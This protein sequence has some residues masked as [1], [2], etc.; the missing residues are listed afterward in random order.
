MMENFLSV[1]KETAIFMLAAQMILHFLPGDKYTKYGKMIAA[2]VIFSRLVLPVLSFGDLDFVTEFSEKVQFYEAENTLFTHELENLAQQQESLWL[3]DLMGSVE[4]QL[5]AVASQNGVQISSVDM[6][7][8]VMVI[9]VHGDS[10]AGDA[11]NENVF[12]SEESS[13]KAQ[14]NAAS[15]LVEPVTV[16]PVKIGRERVKTGGESGGFGQE[17]G[18]V[19]GEK[20]ST[21][22]GNAVRGRRRSDLEERFAKKLGMQ[23]ELVEVIEVG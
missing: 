10:N 20:V 3:Q 12:V 6:E 23:P 18:K 22:G 19:N 17:E 16:A 21:A 9:Q 7:G 1:L 13:G 8:D 11:V 2:T 14:E 4:T 15:G 5:E